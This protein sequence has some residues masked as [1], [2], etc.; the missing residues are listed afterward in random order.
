MKYIKLLWNWKHEEMEIEE[1]EKYKKD[2]VTFKRRSIYVIWDVTYCW[3]AEVQS[4]AIVSNILENLGLTTM[5]K[6]ERYRLYVYYVLIVIFAVI[7]YFLYSLG[8]NMWKLDIDTLQKNVVTMQEQQ[9]KDRM[10]MEAIWER[11]KIDIQALKTEEERAKE[12]K[13]AELKNILSK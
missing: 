6:F 2:D 9:K 7:T 10:L 4:S 1:F 13:D 12:L 3:Y 8:W 11:A 5:T